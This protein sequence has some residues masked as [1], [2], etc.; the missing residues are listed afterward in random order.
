MLSAKHLE[1]E[2]NKKAKVAHLQDILADQ[3]T[4]IAEMQDTILAL[5]DTILEK[6]DYI[7]DLEARL[8]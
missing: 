5:E 2:H 3:K 7:I 8:P 6:Q 4:Y 1:Q